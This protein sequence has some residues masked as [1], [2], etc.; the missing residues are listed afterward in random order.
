[1]T[2][3]WRWTH[4][5]YWRCLWV[6]VNWKRE[7]S[8]DAL[9][10]KAWES[11]TRNTFCQN[12]PNIFFSP[13]FGKPVRRFLRGIFEESLS[14]GWRGLFNRRRRRRRRRRRFSS[15][16]WLWPNLWG[17]ISRADALRHAAVMVAGRSDA[18]MA[19]RLKIPFHYVANVGGIFQR[20]LSPTRKSGFRG[21]I[22]EEKHR[23]KN[24]QKKKEN[25]ISATSIC[26]CMCMCMKREQSQILWFSQKYQ[27]TALAVLSLLVCA[28]QTERW[29]NYGIKATCEITR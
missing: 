20:L 9:I 18:G 16:L 27:V 1:M 3:S 17:P 12:E 29:K 19:A 13:L 22:H 24:L 11:V 4:V 2:S 7:R 6:V 14:L 15:R 23:K 10:A 8:D 5:F 28:W 25:S 26:I 21:N